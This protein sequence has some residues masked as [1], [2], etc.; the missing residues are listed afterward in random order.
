MATPVESAYGKTSGKNRSI[1]ELVTEHLDLVRRMVYQLPAILTQD[2]PQDD[3]ISAGML[4]LVESAHRFDEERGV[5][6][7]TFAYPRIK[8]AVMDYLRQRDVLSKSARSRLTRL[9]NCIAEFQNEHHRKPSIEELAELSDL[10]EG[11][12][13]RFLGYEKW[14]H[15]ASLTGV[16][17]QTGEDPTA[18]IELIPADTETPLEKVEREERLQRLAEAIQELPERQKQIIV[19]YYYEELYMAEMA[20]VLKISESR[21]SQLHTRALYNLSRKLE[22]EQ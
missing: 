13:L 19:M 8:G 9:R 17:E 18:L 6:F 12:V 4:G 11:T 22:G 5:K 7:A 3:L 10:P 15:V 14:D 16:S 1:E 20:E 21:V 2:M